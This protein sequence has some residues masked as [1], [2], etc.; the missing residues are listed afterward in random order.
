MIWGMII[1]VANSISFAEVGKIRRETRILFGSR[2]RNPK[3]HFGHSDPDALRHLCVDMNRMLE[4]WKEM[5][6]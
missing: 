3:L 2:A 4:L 5:G 1:W 6:G